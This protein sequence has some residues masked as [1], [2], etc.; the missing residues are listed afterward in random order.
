MDKNIT[1]RFFQIQRHQIKDLGFSECL[2]QIQ[3]NFSGV[4][5]ELDE[6]LY[7][8]LER[9]TSHGGYIKGEFTRKQ[10]VNIPPKVT[11]NGVLQAS[12]DP[13]AH[14]AAFQYHVQY[15][16]IAV[17]HNR[18][19]MTLP[20]INKYIIETLDHA[21]FEF[22]PILTEQ[23]L[24]ALT[25]GT[26]RKLIIRVANPD[27]LSIVDNPKNKSIRQNLITMKEVFAGPVVEAV[28]GFGKGQ[29]ESSLNK[30]NVLSVVK[31]LMS[32][33]N[34]EN[35]EKIQIKLDE[36][37]EP[38]DLLSEQLKFKNKLELND[39]NIEDHYLVRKSY[40]ESCFKKS[41]DLLNK[42]FG[43]EAS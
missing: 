34:R 10:T 8:R 35:V 2:Q 11:N 20:R 30:T 42:M 21:G 15:G 1:V 4:Y 13:L 36:D 38:I 22:A 5:K 24:Q 43:Q 3:T 17:E 32:S 23:A 31:Y 16:I 18:N 12:T 7:V 19:G 40:I 37:I 27:N 25:G 33:A 26:P 6:D 9:Y 29:R 39:T 41:I 28:V 14:R